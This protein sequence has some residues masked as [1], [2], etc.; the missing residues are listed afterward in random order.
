MKPIQINPTAIKKAMTSKPAPGVAKA[1]FSDVM[2][3][4]SAMGPATAEL[5]G[6]WSGGSDMAGAIL[7]AAFSGVQTAGGA[8]ALNSGAGFGPYSSMPGVMGSPRYTSQ[9]GFAKFGGQTDYLGTDTSVPGTEVPTADLMNS[10]NSNNLQLLE[11]QALMQSNM[12]S[13]R[14]VFE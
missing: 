4:V 8:Q 2:A 12:P 11:L 9:T 10:M 13:S 14:A 3:G 1:A 5:V 7:N 6:Q